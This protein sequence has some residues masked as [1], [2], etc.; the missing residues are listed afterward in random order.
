MLRV[1]GFYLS[2]VKMLVQNNNNNTVNLIY[3][4]N[5][6]EKALIKKIKFIGDKKFKDRK[7]RQVI[8]SE[9]S[10]FWKFISNK[11]YLNVYTDLNHKVL[12]LLYEY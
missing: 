6:G 5:L 1:S 2:D 3:N 8:V 7:L 12:M 10:K 11:K 9:E 4:I